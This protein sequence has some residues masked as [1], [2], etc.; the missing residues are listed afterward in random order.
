M[1]AQQSYDPL[2]LVREGAV[3]S[4]VYTDPEGFER[5]M[6]E[7]AWL[8]MPVDSRVVFE[9]PFEDRWLGAWRLMGIDVERLSLVAGHA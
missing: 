2:A 1:R 3:H 4:S 8:S 9:L 5:E 7:N 6:R